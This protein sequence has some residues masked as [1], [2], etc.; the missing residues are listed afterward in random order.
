MAPSGSLFSCIKNSL[1][2]HEWI[3]KICLGDVENRPRREIIH[4]GAVLDS[5]GSLTFAP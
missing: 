3:L 5:A 2:S 1:K 4:F